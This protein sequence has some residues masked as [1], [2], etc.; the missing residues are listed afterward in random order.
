MPSLNTFH[1]RQLRFFTNEFASPPRSRQLPNLRNNPILDKR[2]S[3]HIIVVEPHPLTQQL[4]LYVAK[5]YLHPHTRCREVKATIQD[6]TVAKI[7]FN[8]DTF[9]K[10]VT[11]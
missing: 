11:Y 7:N 9:K 3:L 5:P 6:D 2:V 1:A 8:S 10:G 4:Q